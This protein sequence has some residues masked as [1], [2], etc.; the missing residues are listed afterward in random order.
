MRM[1]EARVAMLER[2]NKMLQAA[3]LA[4]LDIGVSHDVE[5]SSSAS[6]AL[7]SV[8]TMSQNN[9]ERLG[10]ALNGLGIDEPQYDRRK[11][12]HTARPDSW[13][14]GHDDTSRGSFETTASRSDNSVRVLENM[15]ND[16]DVDVA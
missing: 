8:I 15:L 6:P 12:S 2:Q 9:N 14:S 3:L 7:D 4:A 13:A 1:L 5:R 16:F 10:T 11:T